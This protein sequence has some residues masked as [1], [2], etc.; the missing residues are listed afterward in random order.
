RPTY[1]ARD[2]GGLLEP[3]PDVI[4]HGDAW[5][6]RG[7]SAAVRDGVVAMSGGGDPLDALRVACAAAWSQ[8]TGEPLE[9]TMALSAA[10][11]VLHGR[12]TGSGPNVRA[13]T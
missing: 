11:A 10:A 8:P 9:L 4:G 6:V 13:S 1:L 2:L 7:W 3:H 5:T 12:E